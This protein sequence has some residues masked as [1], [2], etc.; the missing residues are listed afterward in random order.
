[1]KETFK[2]LKE[3]ADDPYTFQ[4]EY[5]YL[6]LPNEEIRLY[7][8]QERVTY[9][10]K[11]KDEWMTEK[12]YNWMAVD[13]VKDLGFSEMNSLLRTIKENWADTEYNNRVNPEPNKTI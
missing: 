5:C 1:M 3:E 2:K 10:D 6:I 8:T 13:T 12:K 7:E 11:H 4:N 9:F